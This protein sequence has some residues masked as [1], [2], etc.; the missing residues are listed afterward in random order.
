MEPY[1]ELIRKIITESDVVL[2]I[3]DARFIELSRNERAEELIEE[4]G[5]PVIFVI[6]KTD[7]AKK[8]TISKNLEKLKERGYVVSISAKKRNSARLLLYVIKKVF[9]E[10][11]KQYSPA[12]EK[13]GPKLK[14]REAKG[15]I[16][17][18]VVGYPNVGK[19][20][21]INM[22]SHKKKVMVSKKAGTTHGIHWIRATKEIKLIDTPGVIPLTREDEIRYGLIG[23]RDIESLKDPEL[24]AYAVIKL[25]LKENKKKEFEKFY[26]II[27]PDSPEEVIDN[28]AER[29]KFLMKGGKFDENK[30]YDLIVRD[31]QQ[32]RLRL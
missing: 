18:G 25:F 12:I 19:S 24:V 20:S 8:D 6:N 1:W 11:G 22:L 23:A 16:V 5:R 29:K 13:F 15:E 14:Y 9:G 31:W 2:E 4:I 32:G 3:L 27:M 30:V 17:V 28:I 21:I 10:H 7:L 26:D